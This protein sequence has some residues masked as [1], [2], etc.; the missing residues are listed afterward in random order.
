MPLGLD[1]YLKGHNDVEHWRILFCLAAAVSQ[2]IFTTQRNRHRFITFPLKCQ[3]SITFSKDKYYQSY[4]I[5]GLHHW[6]RC[7][8]H[9]WDVQGAE[10]EPTARK[11]ISVIFSRACCKKKAIT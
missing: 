11:S 6:Q 4:F 1:H 9:V 3:S 2:P 10:M 8:C 7:L 5:S